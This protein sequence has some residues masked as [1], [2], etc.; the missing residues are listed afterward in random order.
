MGRERESC[1]WLRGEWGG[2][3][4]LPNESQR[5]LDIRERKISQG[6]APCQNPPTLGLAELGALADRWGGP[7]K[8]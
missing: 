5:V 1:S 3:S 6:P 8:P 7:G 2:S 4:G